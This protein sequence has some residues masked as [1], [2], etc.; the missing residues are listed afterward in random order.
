MDA[1]LEIPEAGQGDLP[2][3]PR[4]LALSYQL[5]QLQTEVAES[6]LEEVGWQSKESK[7]I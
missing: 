4:I 6:G 5:L 2:E 3:E 1:E 7:I